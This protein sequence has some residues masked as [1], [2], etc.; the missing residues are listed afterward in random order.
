LDILKNIKLDIDIV[1]SNLGAT[2]SLSFPMF[3]SGLASLAMNLDGDEKLLDDIPYF[4]G[5]W[6]NLH[7]GSPIDFLPNLSTPLAC[8]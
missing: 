6:D 1:A 3:K 4:D 5:P 2:N 7:F 8:H